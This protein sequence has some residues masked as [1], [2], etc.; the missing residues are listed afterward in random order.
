M[1]RSGKPTTRHQLSPKPARSRARA[2]SGGE[3]SQ[4]VIIVG[5]HRSGTTAVT[6][7]LRRL[8]FFAGARVESNLESRFFQRL[9]RNALATAGAKW[10]QPEPFDALLEDDEAS[11]LVVRYFAQHVRSRRAIEHWSPKGIRRRGNGARDEFSWGWK[12]PR[13]TLTLPLWLAVYPTAKVIHIRRHGVDVAESL[14]RRETKDLAVSRRHLERY[15]SVYAAYRLAWRRTFASTSI[16]CSTH[17]GALGLW[18]EYMVRAERHAATLPSDRLF[19]VRYEDLLDGSTS[20]VL[21]GLVRF[22]GLNPSHQRLSEVADYF[23]SS[24]AFAYREHPNLVAFASEHREVLARFGY[25][26]E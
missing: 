15:G 25:S 17:E 18:S 1:R 10:D 11:E 24:R 22:A 26:E 7:L 20:A 6:S 19:N 5:M 14:V 13:N 16:R 21:A 2:T 12:D 8:G 23:D 3:I 9:N 4:P